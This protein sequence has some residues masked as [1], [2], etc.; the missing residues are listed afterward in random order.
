M[1][2]RNEIA[3]EFTAGIRYNNPVLSAGVMELADVTDSKSVGG[4]TVWVRV[5]PPA[6]EEGVPIGCPLFCYRGTR[7]EF[8]RRQAPAQAALAANSLADC[9]RNERR[10][11]PPAP[12]NRKS[13]PDFLISAVA[14]QKA[15]L[16]DAFL[17]QYDVVI[18]GTNAPGLTDPSCVSRAAGQARPAATRPATSS[19][20]PG[21]TRPRWAA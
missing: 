20:R 3:L 5:P 2:G 9:L 4:D 11:P 13:R 8:Q 17:M 6:P 21:R 15:P 16:R 10:V 19:R 1:P 14:N 18:P 7:N 12:E